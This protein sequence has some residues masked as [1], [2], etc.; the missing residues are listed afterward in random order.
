MSSPSE[1]V[2]RRL[3]RT[4]GLPDPGDSK[5][6]RGRVIVVG[7]SRRSPGAAL[8]AG[9][10]TLRVGAGRLALVVPD[11][12]V[13]P[14]GP[15]LPEAALLSLPPRAGEPLQAD[16]EEELSEADAVLLGPGFD[17]AYGTRATLLSVAAARRG[18]LVL[19][20][21]GIGVLP[22]VDRA[23]L[24]RHLVLNA[25][26]E[27]AAILLGRDVST[28]TPDDLVEVAQQYD[29]VVHCYGIVAAADGRSWR[30]PPGAAGL[31]TSGS[32]DVLAGAITGF[33]ARGLDPIRAAVWGSWAHAR[34][35]DRLTDRV[36]VGFLARDIPSELT[37]AI[38]DVDR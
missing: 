21:F 20:A 25:N 5:K 6:S 15:A 4:W 28:N 36:G 27:E 34:A 1:A 33:L 22:T 31:G 18:P 11:P 8:L 7:G 19:D 17:D 9:E 23:L 13:G 32:G 14:L 29:A 37:R 12:L 16:V 2:D 35:G 24:P 10:A 3:L 30:V 26:L 38:V